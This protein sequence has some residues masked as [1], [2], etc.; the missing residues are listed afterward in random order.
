LN[1]DI[2]GKKRRKE[3][4]GKKTLTTSG[5]KN[6]SDKMRK[7][8]NNNNKIFDNLSICKRNILKVGLLYYYDAISSRRFFSHHLKKQLH[9]SE[10][11]QSKRFCLK[12]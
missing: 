1:E 4:E 3:E 12:Y 9:L 10:M 2:F 7:D 8:N 5:S 6:S 11:Y